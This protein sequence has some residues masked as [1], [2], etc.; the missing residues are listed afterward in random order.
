M[1]VLNYIAD[2]ISSIFVWKANTPNCSTSTIRYFIG[3]DWYMEEHSTGSKAVQYHQQ[4]RIDHNVIAW[5]AQNM[6]ESW[7]GSRLLDII[8]I[9]YQLIKKDTFGTLEHIGEWMRCTL[10][11]KTNEWKETYQTILSWVTSSNTSPAIPCQII[12]P[13]AQKRLTHRAAP[14]CPSRANI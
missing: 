9:P 14:F 10:N 6:P 8:T 12:F 7:S 13:P 4:Q 2:M 11:S 3:T 5:E 1:V